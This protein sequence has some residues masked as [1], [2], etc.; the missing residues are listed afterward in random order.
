M[1][2]AVLRMSTRMRAARATAMRVEWPQSLML[3]W[4]Q[5]VQDYAFE[6]DVFNVCAFANAPAEGSGLTTVKLWGRIDGEE[7]EVLMAEAPLGLTESSTNILARLTAYAKYQELAR[8]RD[9]LGTA[10]TPSKAQDIAVAYSLVTEDTN[11]ILVHER[12][13]EEKAQEMPEAHKVPQMLAAGWGGTGSVVRE[14]SHMRAFRSGTDNVA[15]NIPTLNCVSGTPDYSGMTT[16]SVW[17]TNRTSAAARVDALSAGGM[18]DYDIPAFLRKTA[19]FEPEPSS[20]NAFIRKGID[21]LNSMFWKSQTFTGSKRTQPLADGYTGI[22]PAGVEKW[23]SINHESFWPKTYA[24]LRDM[25]LGLAICEW[26]EFEIGDGHDETMVVAAFLNV[27]REF[28]FVTGSG[29]QKSAETSRKAVVN[30]GVSALQDGVSRAI[31]AGLKDVT[32]QTWPLAV[33]N[34]PEPAVA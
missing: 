15:F 25:G 17:R 4:E 27:L 19:D 18:D 3:R 29:S 24:D 31:R 33:V 14:A 23:L 30:V 13:A 26:L 32:A 1:E 34:F 22:T 12:T 21:K 7:A 6:N 16:P 20:V 9:L 11:F 5:S 10:P 28:G 8:E 2:P